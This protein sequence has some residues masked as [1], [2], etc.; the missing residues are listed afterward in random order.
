M[1]LC[2]PGDAEAA[3]EGAARV[4][5]LGSGAIL[6]ESLAAQQLLRKDWGVV[7]DVWSCPSFNELAREGRA[8]ER[9]NLLHPLE[10][11]RT[12]FVARQ[13]QEHPGPVV[14]STDY[15]KAFAEQIRPFI[16]KERG[17]TVL[18]TDGF[19]RS[20]FRG[21]LRAHFEIDRHYITVAAL[22]ALA[23]EGTLPA[24]CVQSA[25]EQY[26][27]AADKLDPLVA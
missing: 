5:L 16:P 15:V 11:P 10:K 7:A 9:W 18:G 23:Q 8:C 14:A 26:G 17:Y 4:Q 6:R 19:G 24:S 3:R 13:L 2:Q 22:H 20:D 25:I 21:K 12:P 1:Y 27:I